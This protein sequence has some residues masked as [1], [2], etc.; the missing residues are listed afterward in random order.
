MAKDETQKPT[1]PSSPQTA[2]MVLQAFANGT[3][4]TSI[5][6]LG[7]GKRKQVTVINGEVIEMIIEDGT[8]TFR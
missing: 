4:K 2:D 1:Q 8:E 5:E 6:V 7:S 3:A